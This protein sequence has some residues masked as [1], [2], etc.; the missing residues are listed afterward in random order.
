MENK[1][2][3]LTNEN[4]IALYLHCGK[5]LSKLPKGKS[6]QEWARTQCGWTV[7]G[8]QVWCT[9]CNCNVVN[10]DFEGQKHPANCTAR[11]DG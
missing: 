8:L 9:R 10:I 5:C 2:N 4:Q 3:E 1:K 6:P 7:K 11:I